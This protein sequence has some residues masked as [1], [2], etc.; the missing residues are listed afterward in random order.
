M[1]DHHLAVLPISK[2]KFGPFYDQVT[3]RNKSTG[4][5]YTAGGSE[6]VS[7][8]M[9]VSD[10]TDILQPLARGTMY[11]KHFLWQVYGSDVDPMVGGQVAFLTGL[12]AHLYLHNFKGTDGD[13]SA[14]PDITQQRVDYRDIEIFV[15]TATNINQLSCNDELNLYLMR[16]LSET[17]KI[18]LG[19]ILKEDSDEQSE[20]E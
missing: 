14:F 17:G 11:I 3:V 18:E 12:E 2:L 1:L 16:I 5:A 15:T 7:D 6:L 4:E 9:K 10:T 19:D 20:E 13:I 8:L